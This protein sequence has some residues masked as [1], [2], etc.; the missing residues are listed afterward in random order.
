MARNKLEQLKDELAFKEKMLAS[1]TLLPQ[2]RQM[3]EADVRRLRN[4]IRTEEREQA[5]R[6]EASAK[7]KARIASMKPVGGGASFTPGM[8]N[9][10]VMAMGNRMTGNLNR[11]LP[12]T[13]T[14]P[15][16]G[17]WRDR[18]SYEN[19]LAYQQSRIGNRYWDEREGRWV[20]G[21]P[22]GPGAM[23]SIMPGGREGVAP[24]LPPTTKD[25]GPIVSIQPVMEEPEMVGM[26]PGE[27]AIRSKY[28][29]LP[30]QRFDV[31]KG[32]VYGR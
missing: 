23:P 6:A 21:A 12:G 4:Q 19:W 10:E 17:Q 9:E 15:S 22:T 16:G 18:E 24:P 31:R 30:P 14:D 28:G 7:E 1:P 32:T 13:F 3:L 2:P 27:A 20:E 25:R 8:T 26:F 29:R 11:G 5:K